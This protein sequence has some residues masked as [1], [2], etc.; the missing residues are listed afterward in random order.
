MDELAGVLGVMVPIVAIVMGV[1]L[2]FWRTYWAHQ[3]RRLQHQERLAMIERG[4]TP[5]PEQTSDETKRRLYPLSAEYALRRG[6][7]LSCLGVG[8]FAANVVLGPMAGSD[9]EIAYMVGAAGAIVASLGVGNFLYFW[10]VRGRKPQEPP[11]ETARP[12]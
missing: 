9:R 12:L 2:A 3:R 4:I 1:G 6:T 7:I 5:P 8:L 10:I 11:Q